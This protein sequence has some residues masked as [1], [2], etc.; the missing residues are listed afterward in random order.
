MKRFLNIGL[1][2]VVALFCSDMM[3]QERGQDGR[4]GQQGRGVQEGRGGQQGRGQ[5]RRPEYPPARSAQG[6]P[7]KANEATP[8]KLKN[9]K[10]EIGPENTKVNFVGIHTGD[11]PK[12]RLGGFKK[13]KGELEMDGEA[14]KSLNIEFETASVWTEIGDKLTGHLKNEDFLDV[15]KYPSA[16][17]ASKSVSEGKDGMVNV[18]GDFTLMGKTNE[19]TIPVKVTE[20][21]GGVLIKGDLKLDR[22]SFGM[23]KMLDRVAKEV[24]ITMSVGEKTKV[25]G[26][27]GRR[28]GGRS[29][30]RGGGQARG[31]G[32]G[33]GGMGFNPTAIFKQA[34]SNKDGKLSGSELKGRMKNMVK[35]ADTDGDGAISSEEFETAMERFRGGGQGGRGA[36]EGRGGG[37]R[38]GGRN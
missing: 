6:A 30:G 23:N 8:V 7:K 13:F 32:R 25:A 21:D 16:K 1:A 34:D 9:G 17:F 31:G 18:V 24:S 26:S 3:A 37:N 22:A 4:G 10:A 15:E 5:D 20:S 27:G 36:Q 19:I 2:L 35:T 29:S 28:T 38:G 12:P 11:D 33:R 14:I